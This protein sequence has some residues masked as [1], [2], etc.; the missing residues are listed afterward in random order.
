MRLNAAAGTGRRV[1]ARERRTQTRTRSG[2]QPADEYWTW[3]IIKP[4]LRRPRFLSRPASSRR[5]RGRRRTPSTPWREGR[6]WSSALGST[7]QGRATA[8]EAL[9]VRTSDESS[10]QKRC[11]MTANRANLKL[12]AFCWVS[13]FSDGR[14]ATLQ[15]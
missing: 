1:A 10:L 4:I 8:D 9:A 14:L 7:S 2:K 11:R 5:R 15:A 13:F 12:S 6:W 3:L